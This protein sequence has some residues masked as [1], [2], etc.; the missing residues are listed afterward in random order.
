MF[1][2]SGRTA[3]V[4]GA[5]GGI[6]A[7]IARALAGRGATVAVSGTRTQAL[8][9]LAEDIGDRARVV[10]A[11]LSS[12]EGVTLLARQAAETL[13]GSI[14]I[15]VNNAGLTRDN[16][17][18]R[19]SDTDWQQVLD[20]NLT[21]GFQLIRAALRGMMKKRWG[22]IIGVSSVV[23]A[24]GNPGQ[25]NYAASKAGMI[26]M[27]KALAQE[28]SSR[29]ITA[30]CVAPGFI[31]TD[32]TANLPAARRDAVL[33]SIPAGVFGRPEDV[34]SAVVFLASPEANYVTGQTLH[35]NGGMAMI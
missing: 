12:A 19:L 32:M 10:P 22:R 3:L 6:G 14:D 31:E 15:L 18:M 11:D 17:V 4:T 30:N 34:A 5:S 23:G 35:I 26:G 13:G 27:T 21:A 25:A 2:L 9:A 29:G 8:D 28:V 1:D 7:A 24:T 16:L 33:A 20:V